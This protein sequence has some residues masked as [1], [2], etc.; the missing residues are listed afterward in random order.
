MSIVLEPNVE[1]RSFFNERVAKHCGGDRAKA[2]AVPADA[3]LG[4]VLEIHEASDAE[5][6]F[7]GHLH[8]LRGKRPRT[9]EQALVIAKANFGW[10]F[11]SGKMSK[12]DILMWQ[13]VYESA[14]S[15][16]P[17]AVVPTPQEVFKSAAAVGEKIK[18]GKDPGLI[19]ALAKKALQKKAEAR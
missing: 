4:A 9:I 11:G 7:S 14:Y 10:C 13:G 6:F 5:R 16:P 1:S 17:P 8:W 2:E 18:A 19:A 3:L 15:A 12:T